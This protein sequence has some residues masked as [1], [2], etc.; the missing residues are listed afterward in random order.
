VLTTSDESE[1]G[2]IIECDLTF[3][4]ESHDKFKEYPPCPEN[5]AP[6]VE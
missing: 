5:I 1:T 3:F 2:Y 6:K 4:V